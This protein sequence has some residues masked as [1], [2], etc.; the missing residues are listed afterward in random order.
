VITIVGHG[1]SINGAGLGPWIDQQTVV[2]L[3]TAPRPVPA[4]WGTRTDFTCARHPDFFKKAVGELW[5]F[6]AHDGLDGRRARVADVERWIDHFYRFAPRRDHKGRTVKPSTGCCAIYCAIEFL[7]A[8]EIAL[9]GFDN[10]FGPPAGKWNCP[11]DPMYHHYAAERAS[12]EDL[13][14]KLTWQ[15]SSNTIP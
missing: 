1:P 7:D 4:D 15:R 14:V 5:L 8:R 10:W 11:H 2:R 6:P 12:V 9:V 3:K 13:G